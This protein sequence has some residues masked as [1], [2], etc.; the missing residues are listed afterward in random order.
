MAK[1]EFLLNPKTLDW[2]L[3]KNNPSVRYFTLVDILDRSEKDTEANE[4]RDEIMEGPLVTKILSK[5]KGPGFWEEPKKFYM[6][7]YKSTVWQLMILA[8][9]GARGGNERVQKACEFILNNAQDRK[10]GGFSIA[11]T[12]KTGGA[13]SG[14][15]PC[16]SGNMV[17]SLIKFGYLKDPRVEHGIQWI[18]TYQRFDDGTKKPPKGWPYDK[19]EMCWGHHA[20]HMGV[21]K[22]LKAL[23]EIPAGLRTNEVKSALA[24]SIEYL[25]K[26]RVYKRS[27][28]LRRVS[29]P[30]WLKFGFPL[31]YQTDVLEILGLL[32]KLGS[33]DGRM[34]EAMDLVISKQDEKGRWKLENSYNGRFHANIERKG[35][36]S[37]WVTLHALRVLKRF[38][39]DR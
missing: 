7:K 33:K 12:G 14:V 22:S 11:G 3:E 31:M 4:A 28:D 9:L 19:W 26:H 25:L 20:C 37:K 1:R 21:V 38:H 36:E 8:E 39:A 2:L 15:I 10:S 27:H 30:G 29:K 17:W 35:K 5:Q 13:P 24:Q 32:T 34:Q 23:S 6:A 16:L 18:T